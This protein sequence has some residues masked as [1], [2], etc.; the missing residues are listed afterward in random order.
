[1]IM[2]GEKLG[3]EVGQTTG[4]RILP[5]TDGLHPV[6]EVSLE[7]SGTLIGAAYQNVG[8]YTA[9]PRSDG[10]FIGEGQGV[11]MTADGAAIM[12][13][14]TGLGRF[15]ETGSQVWRGAL[16]YETTS[17]K[18]ARLN[19]TAC[20]YEYEVAADGKTTGTFMEWK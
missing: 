15:T 2:L 8:T 9:T 11:A 3:E 16:Y 17:E 10:T 5:G 4:R 18:Y 20:V 6:M 13:K 14:G 1:M 19:T 7:G 12:W